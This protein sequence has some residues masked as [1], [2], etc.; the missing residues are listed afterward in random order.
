MPVMDGYEAAIKIRQYMASKE[1]S[2][3][4]IIACTGHTEQEFIEKAWRSEMNEVLSKPL[5][6]EVIKEIL[7]EVFD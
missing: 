7:A 6:L 5:N 2:Q 3:P 4:V 1:L